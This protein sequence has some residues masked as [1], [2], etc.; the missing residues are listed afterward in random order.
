MKLQLKELQPLPRER[1]EPSGD[2]LQLSSDEIPKSWSNNFKDLHDLRQMA[3]AQEFGLQLPLPI[4]T[5]GVSDDQLF[6][7]G[8]RCYMFNPMSSDIFCVEEPVRLQDILHSLR[9]T[10]YQHP[11]DGGLKLQRMERLPE[12]GG[13]NRIPD[14]KVPEGWT[15][16]V[17]PNTVDYDW[18]RGWGLSMFPTT[19]LHSESHLDGTPAYLFESQPSRRSANYIWKP[20]RDEVYRIDEDDGIP[21]IL[22]T[23]RDPSKEFKTTLLEP[24]PGTE[25][26]RVADDE[27][28]IGWTR[29]RDPD[30]CRNMPCKA[31]GLP[32]PTPV[33]QRTGPDGN[34]P[35]YL[36]ESGKGFGQ[37]YYLWN[38]VSNDI[39][40]VQ[41]V[42]GLRSI[43]LVLDAPFR[44]LK[45]EK[46][47]S[48]IS[49]LWWRMLR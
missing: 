45:L 47:E 2:Y 38:A 31:H 10:P 48:G 22:A 6:Q 35:E 39:H 4:L 11:K 8:D 46:L 23:L 26:Y 3:D 27:M 30:A 40:R 43:F 25:S 14:N 42:M 17:D 37:H 13:P 44:E 29:A 7:S 5:H 28:L 21:G 15:N 33:L 16:K 1:F 36:V 24:L 32:L 49:A 34:I 18:C 12:Y 19:L 41:A 9:N 20:A